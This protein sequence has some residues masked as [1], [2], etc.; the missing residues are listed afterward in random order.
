MTNDAAGGWVAVLREDELPPA[1][2]T[3]VSLPIGI[4]AVWRDADGRACAVDAR[5]PHQ[6]SDLATE[7]IVDGAELVC[8]A[9]CWRFDRAGRGTKVNVGGRRDVK[10]D[11][12]VHPCR[13]E[14]GQIEV[15]VPPDEPPV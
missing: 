15:W 12:A 2:V 5:C 1:S 13:I 8:T 4:L 3:G 11:V 7:G 6:W 9:H 10:A 14:H